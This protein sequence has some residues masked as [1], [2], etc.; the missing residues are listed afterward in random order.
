MRLGWIP[1]SVATAMGAAGALC[2]WR[3]GGAGEPRAEPPHGS[4]DVV[5]R[6]AEGRRGGGTEA[7]EVAVRLIEALKDA[8]MDVPSLRPGLAS[9]EGHWRKMQPPW[10]GLRGTAAKATVSYA[11]LTSEEEKEYT[12]PLPNGEVWRPD[13][14]QWNMAEGSFDQ[15]EAIFA[16]SPAKITYR[17]TM[18][19]H[20]SLDFSFAS[21]NAPGDVVF[22]VRVTDARGE[23]R[24]VWTRAVGRRE[25][26]R[27]IDAHVDLSG[28]GGQSVEL[29]LVTET[30]PSPDRPDLSGVPGLAMWGNPVLL[31]REATHV[32]YNVLWIVVDATRADAIAAFHDD[33]EDSAKRAAALPP[34]GALLP[35]VPGVTPALDELAKRSVRFTH[36]YSV[37]SWTRPGTV[38]MLGGAR[39]TELGLDSLHWQVPDWEATRFY[40]SDPPMLP[41]LLRR[42]GI[43][44][45][46]FVNNY[47]MV[48]Y[49]AVGVDMGFEGISDYR[50]RTRDTGEITTHAVQWI[51]EHKD[52]RF[53]V[54][55]NYNSP[56][57]P[58][59]PPDRF[60]ARIPPPPDGPADPQAARYMAEVAKDDDAIGVLMRTLD[61]TGLREHTDRRDDRGPRRDSLVGSQRR[62]GAGPHAG[63]LPPLREQ[64]RG[65]DPRPHPHLVTRKSPR[66]RRRHGPDP[67]DRHRPDHPGPRGPRASAEDDGSDAGP[68]G[69][70]PAGGRAEDRPLGG[71]RDARAARRQL[72]A[73]HPRGEGGDT[74]L[75]HQGG[76]GPR[77]AVRPL[78]G[79]RRAKNL[80]HALPEKAAEMRALLQSL[81]HE[82]P[83][84]PTTSAPAGKD[85]AIAV[86]LRF[87]GAGGAHRV[88]GSVSVDPGVSL[89][90]RAVNLGPEALHG[91][92][93]RVELSFS[94]SPDTPV[95][96]DIDVKPP[97]RGAPL[98]AVRGRARGLP[99]RAVR[100]SLRPRGSGARLG[101]RHGRRARRGV[102]AQGR[103]ARPAPGLRRL[104]DARA[105]RGARGGGT[106]RR[107]RRRR[108]R[109]SSPDARVGLR[110]RQGRPVPLRL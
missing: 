99:C 4:T 91:T 103:A 86:T 90:V 27:W 85:E 39:S 28:F 73:P 7:E 63:P 100:R 83:T 61:D 70:Q 77:G 93:P 71:A 107:G 53:F 102:L 45:R 65:D 110:P 22:A 94:T 95:G 40:A 82:T 19:L 32:P 36:A 96:L 88:S 51:T 57:E 79:P 68:A 44:T 50:Y 12:A 37:A 35:K 18:P 10:T 26:K 59:D 98:G 74:D 80:V 29:Q 106:R 89:V 2:A 9:I 92:S 105:R 13:A 56:H 48:G 108:R 1:S 49:A 55:C 34:L 52:E 21:E 33:A 6:V 101:D 109:A 17:L 76:E 47:F 46:A 11:L 23:R 3:A 16:P 25:T 84:T 66:G 78:D 58:L 41:L 20:A 60:L 64:L 72:P 97:G 24:D 14:R 75:R 69:P 104:R 15:R 67:H 38:A 62:V 87:V 81:V 5:T 8:R 30:R 54:F 43:V 31:A 42:H